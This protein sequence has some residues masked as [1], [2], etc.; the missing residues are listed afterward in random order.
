LLDFSAEAWALLIH[1]AAVEQP[2][3]TRPCPRLLLNVAILFFR[4]NER[5]NFA[6]LT[7]LAAA[8]DRSRLPLP[9]P[10]KKHKAAPLARRRLD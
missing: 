7:P 2:K 3:S 9:A 10:G 1:R 6:A 8:A 4:L 5:P